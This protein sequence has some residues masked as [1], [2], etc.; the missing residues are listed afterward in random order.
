MM[1]SEKAIRELLRIV[2]SCID[3]MTHVESPVIQKVLME[4]MYV[5]RWVLCDDDYLSIYDGLY[6]I[7]ALGNII[8]LHELKYDD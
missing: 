8:E 1:R 6:C 3:T 7:T 4:V 5:L 2:K